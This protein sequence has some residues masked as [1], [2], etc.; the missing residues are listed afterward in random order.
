MKVQI[1]IP[2]SH[3][4]LLLQFL[5]LDVKTRCDVVGFVFGSLSVQWDTG[6]SHGLLALPAWGD[7]G[8]EKKVV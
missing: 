4:S 3:F 8:D 5:P 1:A 6:L 7:V 2:L